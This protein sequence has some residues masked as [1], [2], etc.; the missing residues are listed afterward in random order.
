MREAA[1]NAPLFIEAFYDAGES[2][3]KEDLSGS[4]GQGHQSNPGEAQYRL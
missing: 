2:L 3:R 1:A 4:R